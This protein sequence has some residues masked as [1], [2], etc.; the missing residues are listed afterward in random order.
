MVLKEK[1][2]LFPRYHSDANYGEFTLRRLRPNTTFWH[3]SI[4]GNWKFVTNAQ[5]FRD[6]RD[7]SYAK[8]PGRLRVLTLGDSHTEG[9]EV[10]Q[11]QTYSAVMERFLR[12]KKS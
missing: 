9:F 5:G 6:E 8:P 2:V 1:I 3:T 10:R 12:A 7:F 11:T 4:D